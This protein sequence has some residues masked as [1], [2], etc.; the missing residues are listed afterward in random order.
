MLTIQSLTLADLAQHADAWND[1]WRRSESRLPSQRAEGIRL[2]CETFATESELTALVVRQ[3]EQFVAAL[4]LI[5]ATRGGMLTIYRLPSN[6]T[7][8]AGDLLLDPNADVNDAVALIA[9]Q[10]TALAGTLAVLEQIDT[11]SDRWQCMARRL[12]EGGHELYV[13]AGHDVGVIDILHDWE[14]YTRS[15]SRNH[16]SAVKRTRKKLESSGDVQVI[17]MR[18]PSDQLL[19]ETLEACF[20]IEDRTWKGENGTSIVKTPGMR[21]YF[22]REAKIV[23][24]AGMLDLWLLKLDDQII[25]FE[26]C[27]LSKGT[28]FSH[29]ISFDPAWE[30]FSPGRLLRCYQLQ[31]YHQDPQ[32]NQLDT[33]GVLCQAKAKWTTRSYTNGRVVASLGGPCSHLLLKGL[34]ASRQLYRRV[35]SGPAT[36]EPIPAGAA[37]YL[38]SAGGGSETAAIAPPIHHPSPVPVGES[39]SV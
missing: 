27:H 34:K 31:Q 39:Q 24:D 7:V 32:V 17:R 35:R 12:R 15:W 26:Y 33:L 6:C 37:S 22:H 5:R 19:H 23:R 11:G 2:W 8:S 16:R 9:S 4:P 3:E 1:L 20:A 25:A 30:R 38:D 14:A 36:S 13:S 18:D 28:C 10:L 29:K 21:E